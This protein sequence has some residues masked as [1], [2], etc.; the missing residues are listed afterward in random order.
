M[1]NSDPLKLAKTLMK[2]PST[3]TS[4][5]TTDMPLYRREIL[6]GAFYGVLG[7]SVLAIASP[8]AQANK[9]KD[10]GEF[11]VNF[12]ERALSELQDSSL[13]ELE[14][15]GV[16]DMLGAYKERLA[17]LKKDKRFAYG[18][19]FKNVGQ[20][21][22]A[23]LEHIHSQLICTPVVPLLVQDEM[24][25]SQTYFDW[26][27]RCILCDLVKQE[28]AS[29]T[30]VVVESE[31]FL[32]FEPF[33]SRFPF[34]THVLPKEHASHFENTSEGHLAELAD[35]LQSAIG[36]I[37]TAVNN[38]PYNYLLHTSPLTSP[39]LDSYHW[40]FEIIP[41]LTKV[42]GFEWGSGFYINPLPPENAAKFLRDVK[43]ESK[44]GS[45]TSP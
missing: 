40:H 18:L 33:A 31:N 29:A 8:S 15:E 23:S 44:V 11:L 25:R 24:R 32:A 4:R 12:G 34:E 19:I 39:E 1:K 43:L 10:A 38:P 2:T 20:A 45:K 26:R 41:R 30:R 9:P 13:S 6:S 3:R 22:G 5:Y 7:A 27:G 28:I 14:R 36:R 17:D 42:A 21:A 37:E 35:V 16:V